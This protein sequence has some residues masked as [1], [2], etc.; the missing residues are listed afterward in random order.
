MTD[1]QRS[2]SVS[3]IGGRA[4]HRNHRSRAKHNNAMLMQLGQ[5][6]LGQEPLGQEPLGQEPLGQEPLGQEPLG[7]EPL[8]QEPQEPISE[9]FVRVSLGWTLSKISFGISDTFQRFSSSSS[10]TRISVL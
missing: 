8:G 10:R 5:E 1:R 9:R 3:F 7:Q 4:V 6:P 2:G